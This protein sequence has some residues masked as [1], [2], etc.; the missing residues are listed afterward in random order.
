MGDVAYDIIMMMIMVPQFGAV[1]ANK[2]T[3][4]LKCK[5]S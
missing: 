1:K 3:G 5:R 4:H 2:P